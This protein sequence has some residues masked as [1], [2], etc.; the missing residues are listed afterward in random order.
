[1][2]GRR[3]LLTSEAIAHHEAGHAIAAAAMGLRLVDL[4][5]QGPEGLDG[6]GGHCTFRPPGD[7]GERAFF[8]SDEDRRRYHARRATRERRN[9]RRLAV[10]ALGGPAAHARFCG[11]KTGDRLPG[12]SSDVREARAVLAVFG[13]A[14][15][16]EFTSAFVEAQLIV[17]G[18][19]SAVE[20]V[21]A[22]LLR[23]GAISGPTLRRLVRNVVR[24]GS[25]E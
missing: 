21:A 18:G 24:Q 3:H 11:A 13:G 1:M 10:A 25:E 7:R 20:R 22:E 2:T 16:R 4:A 6:V 5:H 8:E 19:W 12:W 14:A 23:A 15:D 17:T 9:A